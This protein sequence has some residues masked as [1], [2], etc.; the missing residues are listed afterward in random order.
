MS[1]REVYVDPMNTTFAKVMEIFTWG[2]LIVMV[3]FGLLYLFGLSSYVSMPSAISHWGES[4]SK[5]WEETKG[6][7]ISGYLFLHHLN[8]VD[9]LSMV[10]ISILA[11]APLFS[12]IGALF[13]AKKVYV[14]LLLILTAEFIFAI[15]RPLIMK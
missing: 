13:R 8:T 1:K 12:V 9:C 7:H 15:I 10:G 6:I 11:L 4:A 3:I 2:G 14:I 5:F